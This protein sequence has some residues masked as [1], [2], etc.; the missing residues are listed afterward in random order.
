MSIALPSRIQVHMYITWTITAVV[1][2]SICLWI[3]G[4]WTPLIGTGK[5]LW[6]DA[7]KMLWFL[8]VLFPISRWWDLVLYPVILLPV[9]VFHQ[10]QRNWGLIIGGIAVMMIAMVPVLKYILCG[11]LL[12]VNLFSTIISHCSHEAR[13]GEVLEVTAVL[14]VFAALEANVAFGASMT[15]GLVAVLG[16]VYITGLLLRYLVFAFQWLLYSAF[17]L[18]AAARTAIVESVKWWFFDGE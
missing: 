6:F 17:P 12:V 14:L 2:H 8:P 9:L 7:N 3:I 18:V 4:H 1:L 5:M 10:G 15:I 11:I 13:E 16:A